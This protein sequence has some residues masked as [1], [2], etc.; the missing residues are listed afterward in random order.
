V[1]PWREIC[2]W[3]E[4]RDIDEIGDRVLDFHRA[5]CGDR[6]VALQHACRSYWER[7]LSPLGFF[8]NLHRYLGR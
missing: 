3:V 4:A 5:A 2:V 7:Y 6:F 1:I 8:S